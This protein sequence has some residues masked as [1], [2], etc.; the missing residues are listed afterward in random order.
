MLTDSVAISFTLNGAATSIDV[1]CTHTLARVL[2]EQ[3]GLIGTKVSCEQGECGACTV[4]V[5][6]KAVNSC[7]M[8]AAE[9]DGCEVLTIEGL[10]RDGELD[11]IQTAFIEEGAVQ[12]GY[13]TAGMIMSA[14]ALLMEN[15]DPAEAEI[16]EALAGNLCRCT[17]YQRIV[18]AVSSAARK[19]HALDAASVKG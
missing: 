11:P 6:G 3:L 7:I 15:R 13:C 4:I 16:R 2:R 9:V 19:L 8:L 10:A 5:D 17:G 12:C 1:N 18:Q 14:K